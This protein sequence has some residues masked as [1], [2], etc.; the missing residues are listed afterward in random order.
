VDRYAQNKVELV[1]KIGVS[2]IPAGCFMVQ[3]GGSDRWMASVKEKK[4]FS[5]SYKLSFDSGSNWE[6][7]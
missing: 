1:P 5:M 7:Y 4:K 3:Y 6:T 2:P